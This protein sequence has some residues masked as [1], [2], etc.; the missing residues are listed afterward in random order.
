MPLSKSDHN[1]T[2]SF[3]A[4]L[5][6]YFSLLPLANAN[7]RLDSAVEGKVVQI[8]GKVQIHQALSNKWI[9]A[10]AGS[11]LHAGDTIRTRANGKASL[12]MSD[13]TIMQLDR[14]SQMQIT[15]VVKNAGWFGKSVIAQSI[16]KASR[17]VFS[18]ISGKLWARNKNKSVRASFKTTTATIGIRGTELVIEA[19]KDGSVVSTVLEG[20]VEAENKFG[21]VVAEA[22]NQIN[23]QPGQAPQRSILLNPDNAVQWTIVMP[24]LINVD[25]L[26]TASVSSEIKQL[27]KQED[28]AAASQMISQ[29]IQRSPKDSSLQLLDAALD[30]FNGQPL[31]AHKKLTRLKINMPE[32]ALLLRSLATASLMT[33]DKDTAKEAAE[34]VVKLEPNNSA[35]HVVLAYVQQS[36][37]ELDEAMR[38]VNSALRID[39]NNTLASVILA[40]LQFGSGYSQQAMNTLLTAQKKDPTNSI[41]NNLAGFI[42][43]SLHKLDDARNA[44]NIALENDSGMAESHMG[45]GILDMREGKTDRA[46]EE[47]TSA[48]ALDPQRSLF[49]S[50]WGKMLYQVKRY[51]KALDMFDHAALLDKKDPTP[52]FYKSIVL[53][54][55]NRSGEAI[56]ALNK[57]VELND[58]RAV[59][60][61]RFLLDK[62]LAVRNVDLSIL[63]GKLGLSRIAEKKAVAAIKSDYTNYSAHLFY[64]GVLG[65]QDDRSYPAGSEALLARMLQ[66][67]NVNTFNSFNDYT[68]FFE[69]PDIGGLITARAGNFG[70]AGGE[71]IIYG[72]APD[73]NFAYNLGVFSDATDGWR[74]TNSEETTAAAFIGKWQ[75][76][77]ENGLL[78]SAL[79]SEFQQMDRADQRY[80]FDN[81]SSP[82]DELNLNLA[83]IELGYSHQFS[84]SSNLLLYGTYQN[85]TGDFI[86]TTNST[87]TVPPALYLDDTSTAEFERPYYQLQLQ[88]MNK[89]NNH[90]FIAGLLSF[91]G[92]NMQENFVIGANAVDRG[93]EVPIIL[94]PLLSFDNPMPAFDLDI[95]FLS[96]YMQD[97]WQVSEDFMIEAAVYFDKM[98]NADAFSGT[99]W[100]IQ[101]VGPRLGFIWGASE[102]NTIRLS[103]FKYILPF[104]TSRLDPV[105]I[106]GVPIFRNTEEGAII[107]EVDLIWEYDTDNGLFSIGAFNL[108]K[109]T[110][111][112]TVSI[113]GSI[114]GA[115]VSYETLVT[116]TIGVSASY[117]YSEI[118]D[119]SNSTLDRNDQLFIIAIRNQQA[120]GLSMGLKDTYR[121]MD[122]IDGRESP[123]IR[124]LDADIGYEFDD[125]AGKVSLEIKNIMDAEFNW[126]TDRF[127]F[128]GRNPAREFLLSATVNF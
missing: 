117:R 2:F 63:Y 126:L 89:V 127:V 51:D 33:G 49:L 128:A 25:E 104:V 94:D 41:I 105:D 34:K 93:G 90:Q 108:D 121:N 122:F 115:E 67:A 109:E 32:N 16:K 40:Q 111:S 35:S 50:Y 77:E 118:E 47:I 13:E 85:N 27:L 99:S 39:S 56:E 6:F 125:K 22:G 107:Q 21:T 3:L 80:E 65:S 101:E 11:F 59:Y 9:N 44:F 61:S 75:P 106:A 112:D 28:Y 10:S 55:L 83:A 87:L 1:H 95:T 24:P 69:Q 60:R 100:D 71:L 74:E 31:T 42:L 26:S 113:E 52:V 64:A 30:I 45:L 81:L 70:T 54:D 84:P 120:N 43:L 73:S 38:S 7:V 19:K 8:Q 4:I 119:L 68:S 72:S 110:P 20:R 76:S 15:H 88:Y 96:A 78:I 97:S 48:V 91:S 18:L 86:S 92:N 82:E 123:Y 5:I 58:N 17:S 29:Q 103:A 57:A 14:S 12:L 23:I 36:R 79:F 114:S 46:L 116:K 98:E 66:P 53:R 62:D 37:F 124:I 102:N